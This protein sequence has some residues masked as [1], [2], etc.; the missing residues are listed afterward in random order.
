M[1]V[2]LLAAWYAGRRG[3]DATDA[4]PTLDMR[5]T[6]GPPR[7]DARGAPD[8]AALDQPHPGLYDR[9]VR[10]VAFLFLAAVG[11]VVAISGLWSDNAKAIYLLVAAGTLFVVFMQ[12]L[13]PARVLGRGRYWIEGVFAVTFLA[14]LMGLTG[15]LRSPFLLGYFL[16]IGGAVLSVEGL[17]PVL[18][19]LFAATAYALVSV[20]VADASGVDMTSP[21][22]L[23]LVAFNIASLG[24]LAF[25][26]TVTGREQRQAREA[27]VRLSRFDPLTGLYNRGHYFSVMDREVR[28][29]ARM[30]RGFSM[31]ML[32]LDDLKP[33]NDTFGHQ[34]GDRLLQ[35]ITEVLQRTVRATD[36]AA[37]YGGDEFVVLLPETDLQGAFIVAEKLRRDVAALTIRVDERSVRT[38]VSVGLVSFP[39]DGETIE[40]L[41]SAV[42]AAMYEAKRRGKNQ[43]VGYTTRTE[44]V[45]TSIGSERQ[46]QART[47]APWPDEPRAGVRGSTEPHRAT[48]PH[49]LTR[50]PSSDVTRGSA[51]SFSAGEPPADG[52]RGTRVPPPWQTRPE[53]TFGR[54]YVSLNVEPGGTE[55]GG[56][57]PPADEPPHPADSPT[58]HGPR[59]A[60][61]YR[62]PGSR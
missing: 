43:I 42:D 56:A 32:D 9:V 26:A 28:R 8:E 4:Q 29:S 30:G 36:T 52:P 21:E 3:A 47:R 7:T 48:E 15:G 55:P 34:Y 60:P 44:R 20:L 10:V 41:V 24:L 18:L 57:E 61:R 39:E 54:R 11:V 53:P 35:G 31:L 23:A 19:A 50:G 12:D 51:S 59:G 49:P 38:S 45:A 5:P 14:V 37:R 1:G 6:N 22:S 17:A 58:N 25:I 33:V 62:E 46:A 13:L 16:L 40:Q 2:G 27:A